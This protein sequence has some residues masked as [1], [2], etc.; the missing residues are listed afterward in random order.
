MENKNKNLT[1]IGVA[2]AFALL[3]TLVTCQRNSL[4][5]QIILEEKIKTA[6][7]GLKIFEESR[8]R[9][10][11][12]LLALNEKSQKEIDSLKKENEKSEQKVK[13][14]KKSRKKIKKQVENKTLVQVADT[15]RTIYKTDKVVATDI[16]VNL[17]GNIPN[18][19]LSDIVEKDS[20][21]KEVAEKDKQLENKDNI[22][23]ELEDINFNQTTMLISAEEQIKKEKENSE[24]KDKLN[25]NLTKQVK[26]PRVGQIL[27]GI[28]A[29]II[30]TL[31]IT[32]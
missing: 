20:L 8:L 9:E 3:I 24:L 26:K 32:N 2:I 29:G 11:D 16:S 6:E 14:L 5:E 27:I 7:D 25:K 28:T 21:E 1:R 23:S 4:K 17:L 15:L 31:L 13:D 22:I 10:K 30:G 12:S 18:K 19:V